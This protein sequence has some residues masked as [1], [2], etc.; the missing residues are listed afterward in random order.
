[1][2]ITTANTAQFR[3]LEVDSRD[4]NRGPNESMMGKLDPDGI[5]VAGLQMIHNDCEFRTQWLVKLLDRSE[6]VMVWMDNGFTEFEQNT[7]E[8]EGRHE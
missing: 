8:R 1:M 2:K 6:P 7:S 4:R 3:A 5:H